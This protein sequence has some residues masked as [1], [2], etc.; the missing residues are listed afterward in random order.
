MKQARVT[1]DK[2]RGSTFAVLVSGRSAPISGGKTHPRSARGSPM[3]DP[4]KHGL[5]R[6]LAAVCPKLVGLTNGRVPQ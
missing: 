2:A 6:S 5:Q 1:A 4:P 3:R